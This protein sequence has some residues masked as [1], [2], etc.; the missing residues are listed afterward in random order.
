MRRRPGGSRKAAALVWLLAAALFT[1]MAQMPAESGA[2]A[3]SV[4]LAPEWTVPPAPDLAKCGF[5]LGR[6]VQ[7]CRKLLEDH[8]REVA[9]RI[10]L[11]RGHAARLPLAANK[12]A[13]TIKCPAG[14]FPGAV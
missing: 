2:S 9:R 6:Q 7:G 5:E 10:A 11:A 8:G 13:V 1:A 12:A 3:Q 14:A 4:R